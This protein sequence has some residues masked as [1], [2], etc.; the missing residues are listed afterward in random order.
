MVEAMN[1]PLQTTATQDSIA[2]ITLSIARG[3]T[4]QSVVERASAGVAGMADVAQCRI[5]LVRPGDLCQTCAMRDQCADTTEC[6]HLVANEGDLGSD[7]TKRQVGAFH[8]VPIGAGLLGRIAR[9]STGG[10]IED[11]SRDPSWSRAAE[12]A[13]ASGIRGFVVEPML[14]DESCSGVIGAFTRS[15]ATETRY[16]WIRHISSHSA[17]ALGRVQSVERSEEQRIRLERE[18]VA[19]RSRIARPH[20]PEPAA[21]TSSSPVDPLRVLPESE[22]RHQ[23]RENLLK[24]LNRTR[25]KI[26]GSDGAAALMGLRPTTLVSRVKKMNLVKPD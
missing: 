7:D 20:R 13:R 6:L 4:V 16:A 11:V 19:L 8:R 14:F 12:W 5:W 21:A 17:V 3:G 24:A 10:R 2:G 23:E 18:I 25:W 22:I 1:R 15:V 9:S 26:Y